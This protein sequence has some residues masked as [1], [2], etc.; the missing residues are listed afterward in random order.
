MAVDPKAVTDGA[1]ITAAVTSP[2]WAAWLGDVN[3]VLTTLTL[4]VGLVFGVV[5][6]F[7][8]VQDR[9]RKQDRET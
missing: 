4:I 1:I 2:G 7:A 3:A 9:N 5:R 6:L 8:F